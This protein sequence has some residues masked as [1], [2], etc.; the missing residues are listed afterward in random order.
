MSH[1][2]C[3]LLRVSSLELAALCG[4]KGSL[5]RL[6]APVARLLCAVLGRNCCSRK[7]SD[8]CSS[9]LLCGVP[10]RYQDPDERQHHPAADHLQADVWQHKAWNIPALRDQVGAGFSQHH[11][12]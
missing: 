9:L 6:T 7:I 5:P 10:Q 4:I 3:F 11:R 12:P 1:C 2:W 8:L